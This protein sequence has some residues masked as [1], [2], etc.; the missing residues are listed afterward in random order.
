LRAH[1]LHPARCV[2]AVIDRPYNVLFLCTGNSARSV[3]GEALIN[4]WGRGQFRGFSAGSHPRGAVH[5]IALELLEH[6]RI[7][8]GGARC[9]DWAEFAAPGAPVMDFVFTVCD[10]AAAE[11]CPV[12]PGQPMTAQWAV[13]DPAIVTRSEVEQ[14]VAFRQAFKILDTRIKL[15][16]SLPISSLDNIRLQR[17][18]DDIGTMKPSS[19]DLAS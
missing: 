6:M 4:R 15:F 1:V 5:P 12:W 7:P 2:N 10:R 11:V 13:E 18:L 16:L 17:K 9:K 14:W 3:I 19:G 8:H